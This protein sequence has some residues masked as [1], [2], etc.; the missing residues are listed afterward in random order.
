MYLLCNQCQTGRTAACAPWQTAS[1]PRASRS[2]VRRR[3]GYSGNRDKPK[4]Q[5]WRCQGHKYTEGAC[6]EEW[7]ISGRNKGLFKEVGSDP[8]LLEAKV[9]KTA[10]AFHTSLMQ[11]AQDWG[12]ALLTFFQFLSCGLGFVALS[13]SSCPLPHFSCTHASLS[14]RIGTGSFII[15]C[16]KIIF[17]RFV[18][19]RFASS[20]SAR[21]YLKQGHCFGKQRVGHTGEF[22]SE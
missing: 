5:M 4:L 2:A 18:F 14:L 22:L 16:F 19:K 7:G 21:L 11:P 20:A 1:S 9:L 6:R 3:H 8:E 10:G 12:C 15:S 17:V 13:C